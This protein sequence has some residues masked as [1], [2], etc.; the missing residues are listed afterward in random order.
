MY[1]HY[2]YVKQRFA[3][4]KESP[5]HEDMPR[6]PRVTAVPHTLPLIICFTLLVLSIL[7]SIFQDITYYY[8]WISFPSAD[9]TPA[10]WIGW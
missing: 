8:G 6:T 3:Y 9:G 10:H 4:D 7:L 5:F 1:Q 2:A